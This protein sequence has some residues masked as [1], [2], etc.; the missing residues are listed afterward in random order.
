MSPI[1]KVMVVVIFALSVA[2]AVLSGQLFAKRE[3]LRAEYEGLRKS[4]DEKVKA[5]EDEK[6]NL[7][8]AKDE[9]SGKL[10]D[11]EKN[12][13]T[14]KTDKEHLTSE[15]TKQTEQITQKDALLKGIQTTIEQL[16]GNLK[17]K[18]ER[19]AAAEKDL[20]ETRDKLRE[21]QEEARQKDLEAKKSA[22][23]AKLAGDKVKELEIALKD[24]ETKLEILKSGGGKAAEGEMVQSPVDALVIRVDRNA[25]LVVLNKGRDQG[26][27]VGYIFTIYRG[28]TYLGDVK[29]ENV[30]ATVA[31]GSPVAGTTIGTIREGDNA[32]TRIR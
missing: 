21:A 31:A 2:F 1:A 12:L 19:L 22:Q 32:S 8:A 6:K 29:I 15:N 4:S 20:G 25:N 5:L 7:A 16:N 9:L 13:A 27:E 11:A 23:E 28:D 18:D 24:R 14:L 3:K 17:N 30:A 26:V 10:Q